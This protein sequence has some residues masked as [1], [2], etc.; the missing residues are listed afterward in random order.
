[1][2]TPTL[3]ILLMMY[4]THSC[5]AHCPMSFATKSESAQNTNWASRCGFSG[6]MLAP[7]R[8]MDHARHIPVGQAAAAV[9]QRP[10]VQQ[11]G[12]PA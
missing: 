7:L 9:G 5:Y 4:S 2:Y 10:A 11:A 8:L 3:M 12:H 1:M 6:L